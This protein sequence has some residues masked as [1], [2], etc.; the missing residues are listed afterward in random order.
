MK[1]LVTM[2]VFINDVRLGDR[3]AEIRKEIF[4]ECF[5]AH[6]CERLRPPGIVDRDPRHGRDRRQVNGGRYSRRELSSEPRSNAR[7]PVARLGRTHESTRFHRTSCRYGGCMVARG[8]RTAAGE[9]GP[10]RSALARGQ[11]RAGRI[12]FQITG[13][14]HQRS[15]PGRRPRDRARASLC[16][17]HA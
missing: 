1:D 8:S 2:T 4:K 11:R 17:R 7:K 3:L 14:R 12:Q 15:G 10:N 5:P 16:Q 9:N 13:Q 6:H